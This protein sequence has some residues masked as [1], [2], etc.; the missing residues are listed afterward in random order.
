[1][2]VLTCVFSVGMYL[3]T[4]YRY[5]HMPVWSGAEFGPNGTSYF[6]VY[7]GLLDIYPVLP[8]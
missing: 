1:M 5:L 3:I 7:K 6:Y 8:L 2:A 4:I